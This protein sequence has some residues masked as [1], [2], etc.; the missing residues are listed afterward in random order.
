MPE[1]A[2]EATVIISGN[3]AQLR[4][5]LKSSELAT[6]TTLQKM[7]TA[8]SHSMRG[9][10]GIS[11]SEI[12]KTGRAFSMMSTM[13][14]SELG[15][16][17]RGISIVASSL[18]AWPVAAAVAGAALIGWLVNAS[19]EAD[20]LREK[21]A[22]VWKDIKGF[23]SEAGELGIEEK[24]R[25]EEEEFT[26]KFRERLKKAKEEGLFSKYAEMEQK[27]WTEYYIGLDRMHSKW[28]REDEAKRQKEAKDMID[29]LRKSAEEVG[30]IR[31][32]REMEADDAEERRIKENIAN[33]LAFDEE[34][35]AAVQ[36]GARK[37][38]E[39]H[40]YKVEQ[41]KKTRDMLQEL[42]RGELNE[43]INTLQKEKSAHKDALDARRENLERQRAEMGEWTTPAQVWKRIQTGEF[44]VKI[45]EREE[46]RF[47]RE[48]RKENTETLKRLDAKIGELTS[49]IKGFSQ[50]D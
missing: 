15:G 3:E 22:Q 6:R 43:A 18:Y 21:M 44:Q 10:S 48:A 14:G 20:K 25:K 31:E 28:A 1:V 9:M 29:D 16:I 38:R 19:K 12:R 40:A 47:E 27:I 34:L 4:D 23:A 24:R 8:N 33:E 46:R 17:G 36:E 7:E 35:A 42:H 13:V 41:D 11:E 30:E 2:G 39:A 37:E 49:V 5:A 50:G 26:N 45:A 32:R